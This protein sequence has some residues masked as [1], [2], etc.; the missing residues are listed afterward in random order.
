FPGAD[1]VG[2]RIQLTRS[3]GSFEVVGVVADVRMG[4]LDQAIAPA[5]YVSSR[6]DPARSAQLVVRSASSIDALAPAIRA[7]VTALD[8]EVPVYAVRTLQETREST[9]AVTTRRVILYPLLIFALLAAVIAAVGVYALLGYVVADRTQEIGV[10]LALGAAPGRVWRLLVRQGL[11]PIVTGTIAGAGI[12]ALLARGLAH[13]LFGVRPL[14]PPTFAAVIIAMVLLGTVASAGP[15][16]R[17][18]RLDPARAT[19]R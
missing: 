5:F 8:T 6:Q 4:E 2:R 12:A 13:W 11:T 18:A 15:A 10:R 9:R 17:A 7:V 19:G 1:A 16:R 3:A 14:D